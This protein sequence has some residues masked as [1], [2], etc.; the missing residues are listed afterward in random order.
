MQ[1][2]PSGPVLTVL[3]KALPNR[4]NVSVSDHRCMS[5]LKPRLTFGSTVELNDSRDVESVS[6]FFPNR[7][8]QTVTERESK[9]VVSVVRCGFRVGEISG[10]LSNVG[11][12]GGFGFRYILHAVCRGEL[13]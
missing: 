5:V 3:K 2:T 10:N 1:P 13:C 12:T 8:A 4:T 11:K 6:E 9:L 7:L